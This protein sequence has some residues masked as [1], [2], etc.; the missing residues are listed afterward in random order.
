MH[1]FSPLEIRGVKF[2]NRIAVS[3]MCQ[4]S[5]VDGF[6]TDWHLV[7]LGSR[8]V[9]G[10]AIVI[11][12]ATAVEQRGQISAADL[13]IWKDDAPSRRSRASRRLFNLRA[14]C[15]ASSWLTP[16]A[17]RAPPRSWGRIGGAPPPPPP[18]GD[19]P[20]VNFRRF[21]RLV[22]TWFSPGTGD[23]L[24]WRRAQF[25]FMKKILHR[26]NLPPAKLP[27]FPK[28]SLP[29]RAALSRPGFS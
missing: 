23:G 4:Y 29:P 10:A 16:A 9:G 26:P 18:D 6:A 21:R 8:A 24:P 27:G 2:R 5:C 11:A 25:R 1:L 13:G 12:E 14:P 19:R 15:R 7:H 17:K 28:R 22:S 20:C 3:P